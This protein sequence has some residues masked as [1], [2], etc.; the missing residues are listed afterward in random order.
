[1]CGME[2]ASMMLLGR[3]V[4]S[5]ALHD[6]GTVGLSRGLSLSL[7]G[8]GCVVGRGVGVASSG[9][10]TAAGN[11]TAT[12]DSSSDLQPPVNKNILGGCE[13]VKKH[14]LLCCT[15]LA[16]YLKKNL[17]QCKPLQYTYSN[18]L[19]F[20]FNIFCSPNVQQFLEL[21]MVSG[22]IAVWRY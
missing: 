13:S 22:Y 15:L 20:H 17:F 6:T 1:M 18:M 7:V 4:C 5:G 21:G 3:A 2:M 9:G 14:F 8:S 16:T 12:G 19:L 10:V 11:A